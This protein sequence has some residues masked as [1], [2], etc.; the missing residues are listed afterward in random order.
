MTKD[1]MIGWHHQF[2]G[3]KFDHTPGDSEGQGSLACCSP[4]GCK[5][6]DMTEQP[7]NKPPFRIQYGYYV[8]VSPCKGFPGCAMVKHPMQEMQEIWVRSL[9][10]EDPLKK[11]RAT[12]SSI[13]A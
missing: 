13:L 6:S 9:G 4:W 2:N 12:H 11:E 7:N 1:E 3:H 8:Y 5:E 10:Q